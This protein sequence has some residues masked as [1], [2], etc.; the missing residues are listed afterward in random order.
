M[1][2]LLGLRGAVASSAGRALRPQFG[3]IRAKPFVPATWARGVAPAAQHT[4]FTGLLGSQ[5][6]GGNQGSFSSTLFSTFAGQGQGQEQPYSD[7]DY[8]DVDDFFGAGDSP[9]TAEST[10]PAEPRM[11]REDL[12]RAEAAANE[13][14]QAEFDREQFEL[15][16]GKKKGKKMHPK[17][18][19]IDPVTGNKRDPRSPP[20]VVQTRDKF[21]HSDAW[22]GRKNAKAHVWIKPGT[23]ECFVNRQNMVDYFQAFSHRVNFIRPFEVIDKL[24]Q[25]DV[26]AHASGGGKSG[27]A[28]AIRHGIAR[29][30]NKFDPRFRPALKKAGYITRDAR[31]V[32][33]KHYGRKKA[34]KGFTWV[35]R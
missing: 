22:G 11:T 5:F 23:G 9:A 6:A 17:A 28:G 18:V 3:R 24:G 19:L 16:E 7:D 2:R 1:K 32:E 35:K 30:L 29:A 8:D 25:F 27:Q 12:A 4:R 20:P 33:R 34:R 10:Q 31:V 13:A 14:E 15:G 21:G 26:Y